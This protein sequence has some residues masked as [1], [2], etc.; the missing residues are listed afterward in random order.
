MWVVPVRG[1]GAVL[2]VKVLQATSWLN[3]HEQYAPALHHSWGIKFLP[4]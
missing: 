4:Q 1:E 3:V 2:A